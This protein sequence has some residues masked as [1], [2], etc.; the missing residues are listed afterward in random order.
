MGH[1][2]VVIMGP[3]ESYCIDEA[4]PYGLWKQSHNKIIS[5][6]SGFQLLG[7]AYMVIKIIPE[8]NLKAIWLEN[9][10][11]CVEKSPL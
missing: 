8:H 2:A 3:R 1:I 10:I 9:N 4:I 11:L 5:I 6:T 7:N